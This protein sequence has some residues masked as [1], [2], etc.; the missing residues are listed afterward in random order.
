V[1]TSLHISKHTFTCFSDASLYLQNLHIVQDLNYCTFSQDYGGYAGYGQSAYANPYAYY[2]YAPSIGTT[3]LGGSTTTT[4]C[5]QTYQLIAPSTGEYTVLFYYVIMYLSSSP[6]L[7]KSSSSS[8]ESISSGLQE[9]LWLLYTTVYLSL[10]T[11]IKKVQLNKD[12]SLMSPSAFSWIMT[13]SI[14]N[15]QLNSSDS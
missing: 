15:V 13:G 1:L 5:R 4:T 3:P 14:Q 8:T 9:L 10:T 11:P 2:P 7:L 6:P 12:T